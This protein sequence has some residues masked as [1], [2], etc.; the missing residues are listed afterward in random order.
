MI[1]QVKV[2]EGVESR[3]SSQLR[4]GL[5]ERTP[6]CFRSLNFGCSFPSW[7][8]DGC[9]GPCWPRIPAFRR[10]AGFGAGRE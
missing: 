7:T 6:W 8:K 10:Y 1:L 4:P 5:A 3:G 9:L 2:E